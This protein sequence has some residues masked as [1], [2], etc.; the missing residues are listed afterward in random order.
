MESNDLSTL[1]IDE[2]ARFLMAHEQRSKK[3]QENLE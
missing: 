2:L 1:T 3:K